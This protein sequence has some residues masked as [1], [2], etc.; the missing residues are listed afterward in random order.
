MGM[1][2]V[3]AGR[4]SRG[5]VGVGR[6]VLPNAPEQFGGGAGPILA[7]L[8]FQ[9]QWG[10]SRNPLQILRA[11]VIVRIVGW[12]DGAIGGQREG[13]VTVAKGYGMGGIPREMEVLGRISGE[14]KGMGMGMRIGFL[15]PLAEGGGGSG[16]GGGPGDEMGIS[17]VEIIEGGTRAVAAAGLGVDG[18][19]GIAQA[20]VWTAGGGGGGG[21]SEGG[22]GGGGL[23]VVQ[24][25]GGAVEVVVG[26][27]GGGGGEGA[28]EG[29]EGGERRGLAGGG[30][31][32]IPQQA[33]SL[34]DLGELPLQVELAGSGIASLPPD[35]A[36]RR[37]L[38]KEAIGLEQ[39]KVVIGGGGVV[40]IQNTQ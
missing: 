28:G 21:R 4:E 29:A 9:K 16:G 26:G 1:P 5:A 23:P 25:D 36:R 6:V 14:E 2:I 10:C 13:R 38:V 40:R 19:A 11:A 12:V 3:G 7:A 20:V 33:G 27:G 31:A 17:A 39:A 30:G 32:G 35:Y 37:H 24:E 8:H 34:A 18:I 15:T 22:G